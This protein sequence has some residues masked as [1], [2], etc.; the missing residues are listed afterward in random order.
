[1]PV[2]A[3]RNRIR[4]PLAVE[5]RAHGRTALHLEAN[6]NLPPQCIPGP[7]LSWLSA[8]WR[9]AVDPI[10]VATW[11]MCVLPE[12]GLL[13]HWITEASSQ[14]AA[15]LGASN[16]PRL[17]DSI[18]WSQAG[19]EFPGALTVKAEGALA[20]AP[21]ATPIA[22]YESLR[23]GDLRRLLLQAMHRTGALTK[24]IDAPER[25]RSPSLT[26]MRPKTALT[27]GPTGVR[28]RKAPPGSLNTHIVKIEDARDNPG[29]AGIESL[30]QRALA[31]AGVPAALTRSAIIGDMQCVVSARSDRSVSPEGVVHPAHQ[32]D[33]RQAAGLGVAKFPSV[34]DAH[35]LGWAP[36]YRV[37]QS[38]A[39]DP[40]AE[41][42][43]LTALIAAAVLLRHGD[44]HRANLG[45]QLT[46]PDDGPKR[47][48]LAPAYDVSSAAGTRYSGDIAL[49][50]GMQ[51]QTA[52]ISLGSWRE[53]ARACGLD[54]DRTLAVVKNTSE[55]LPDAFADAR[56]HCRERDQNRLQDAVDRRAEATLTHIHAR[57]GQFLGAL[58]RG[59]ALAK[60]PPVGPREGVKREPPAEDGP[61][62]G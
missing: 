14:L 13:D 42:A 9:D 20:D 29:E 55:A 52:K 18:L 27:P 61:T 15:A 54:L 32:E 12:N 47:V 49:G 11:L 40:D 50:V 48:A 41:C 5:V 26:G 58:E 21:P 33:Y 6:P 51:T 17:P 2:P 60:D 7:A 4:R 24:R 44:F 10:T 3:G 57:A 34:S 37:L 25:W 38:G 62:P 36:A 59:R 39:V 46:A 16:P 22:K 53:H 28:W 8:E 45:F 43:K 1:M 30:C 35:V 31:Q 23:D 19:A 56:S